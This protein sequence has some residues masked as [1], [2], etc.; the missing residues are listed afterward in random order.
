MKDNLTAEDIASLVADCVEGLLNNVNGTMYSGEA[1]PL[2]MKKHHILD[3]GVNAI[4]CSVWCDLYING[5]KFKL[6]Y[7]VKLRRKR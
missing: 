7:T 1:L 3:N 5:S 6:T 4:L 2:N